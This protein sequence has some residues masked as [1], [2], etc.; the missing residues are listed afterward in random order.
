MP[1]QLKHK[2]A[3]CV[4]TGD[5]KPLWVQWRKGEQQLERLGSRGA[6]LSH[7]KPHRP[8]WEGPEDELPSHQYSGKEILET[9]SEV[10]IALP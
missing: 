1:D 2:L 8:S 3:H 6:D 10:L 4:R 5:A 7:F 9:H